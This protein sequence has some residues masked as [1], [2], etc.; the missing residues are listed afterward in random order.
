MESDTFLRFSLKIVQDVR[1]ENT[2]IKLP[3]NNVH[4]DSP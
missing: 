3:D 2:V 4:I 1:G